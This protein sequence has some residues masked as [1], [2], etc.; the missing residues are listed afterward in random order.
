MIV[1]A[2]YHSTDPPV[3][4]ILLVVMLVVM[5]S[6]SVSPCLQQPRTAVVYPLSQLHIAIK[7]F[8]PN[9]YRTFL[10]CSPYRANAKH[11]V[12]VALAVLARL[13]PSCR[14][15][16]PNDKPVLRERARAAECSL[17]G[18]FLALPYNRI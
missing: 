17:D 18:S 6:P 3:P 5:P 15:R 9:V 16:R 13:L 8:L 10:L 4:W 7:Q 11:L 1:T 12:L 2:V 14:T